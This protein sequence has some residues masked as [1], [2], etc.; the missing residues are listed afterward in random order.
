MFLNPDELQELTGYVRARSQRRALN[1]MGIG[2]TVRPDGRV[3]V[4]R[5]VAIDCMGGNAAA[6]FSA[7]AEPNWGAI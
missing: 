3:L 1:E 6:S 7:T 2:H 5:E 4:L